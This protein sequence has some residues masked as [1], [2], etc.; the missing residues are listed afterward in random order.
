MTDINIELAELFEDVGNSLQYQG[1]AWVKVNSYLSVAEVLRGLDEPI[2]KVVQEGRLEDVRG[3]GKAIA[4]KITA[5]LENGTFNLLARLD[6]QI[7][8]GARSMIRDGVAPSVVH[9]LEERDIDTLEKL[10]KA[11]EG[12]EIDATSFPTAIRKRFEQYLDQ[13]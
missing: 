10:T 4:K 1:E 8:P 7:P 12:G 3:V 2:D 13:G 9:Y 11:I 6:E 5:Y